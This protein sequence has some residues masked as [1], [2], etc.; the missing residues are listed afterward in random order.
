MGPNILTLLVV[1]A[2]LG[3]GW[4][5]WRNWQKRGEIDRM[6]RDRGWRVDRAKVSRLPARLEGETLVSLGADDAYFFSIYLQIEG[7]HR[8]R[9]FYL[10]TRQQKPSRRSEPDDRSFLFTRLSETKDFP[11][12][13]ILPAS[14]I[15]KGLHSIDETLAATNDAIVLRQIPIS[16]RFDANYFVRGLPGTQ[17]LLTPERQEA[18]LAKPELFRRDDEKWHARFTVVPSLSERHAYLEFPSVDPNTIMNRLDMLMDW[19]EIVEM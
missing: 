18:I 9:P 19:V 16:E 15:L 12:L 10:L 3:L 13:A 14:T 4:V 2:A 11:P 6:A 5:L 8:G 7:H 17:D 1:L